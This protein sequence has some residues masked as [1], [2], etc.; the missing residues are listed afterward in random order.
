[1]AYLIPEYQDVIRKPNILRIR[2]PLKHTV[3]NVV[4]L[5]SR[6][7]DLETSKDWQKLVKEY[8]T[9]GIMLNPDLRPKVKMVKLGDLTIDEDIQRALDAKHCSKKIAA[10]HTFDER[11]LQ[12]VYCVKTPGKE[13]YCA[14]DGQHTATTLAGLINA[15]L[16]IGEDDWRNIEIAV[17]YIET[18]NK[19]FARKAFA[20]IN[21]K[22]KKKIS[23]WYEHRTKVMSV[24][25]DGSNDEEDRTAERKQTICEQYDCYPV[26]GESAFVGKPGTFTHMQALNLPDEVLEMACKFHNE[27]FHYDAIDGSLWFM[28]DDIYKA[29]KAAKIKITDEFLKE[30]AGILQ[31]YF[32]GLYEFHQSVHNAHTRWGKHTYGYEVPWQDDAIAAVLVSLYKKF[33]GQQTIPQP[34]LDRFEKI[35]DFVDDDIKDLYKEAA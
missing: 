19:A 1:M 12:V 5:F 35:L 17:L 4:P 31:G 23:P 15:G 30:L 24:R 21:G 7:T 16:F 33:G 14:V 18:D 3:S 20:L 8:Q 6:L 27:Y 26:D 10:V 22:G 11:L 25:I 9:L 28:M 2:N 32:A 13:E 34:M 29:F